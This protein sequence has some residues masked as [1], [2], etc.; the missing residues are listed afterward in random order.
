MK[1]MLEKGKLRKGDLI[2]VCI[3]DGAEWYRENV[4]IRIIR[5]KKERFI[6]E[7]ITDSLCGFIKKKKDLEFKLKNIV[8]VLRKEEIIERE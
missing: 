8:S 2:E 7:A 4:W 6:G 5:V 1:E 3:T